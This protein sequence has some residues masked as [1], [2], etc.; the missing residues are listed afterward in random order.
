MKVM[1][2]KLIN[3]ALYMG[4]V[5]NKYQRLIKHVP[6]DSNILTSSMCLFSTYRFSQG[7]TP[8]YHKLYFT[9]EE[10]IATYEWVLWK[11]QVATA[12][13]QECK[14]V[15]FKVGITLS[16]GSYHDAI[17]ALQDNIDD[18]DEVNKLRAI[19]KQNLI[20]YCLWT[21]Y[22]A[23]K[24]IHEFKQLNQISDE[25]IDTWP[26]Y[27][28]DNFTSLVRNDIKIMLYHKRELDMTKKIVTIVNGNKKTPCFNGRE[29]IMVRHGSSRI[30]LDQLT[31]EQI[32]LYK[33]IWK[34]LIEITSSSLVVKPFRDPG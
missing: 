3:K 26:L 15:L 17:T 10:A 20:T 13:W 19:I 11:S 2:H 24:K 25:L 33:T 21:L 30:K 9:P 22:T 8:K 6:T 16:V 18:N 32:L 34:D 27:V 28:I 31:A 4:Q 14:Q 5:A 1:I 12:L 23:D 29:Q 7:Y